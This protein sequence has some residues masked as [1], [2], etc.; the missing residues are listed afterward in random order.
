M[1]EAAIPRHQ[2]AMISSESPTVS[3]AV[4]PGT[5]LFCCAAEGTPL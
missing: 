1:P 4:L 5:P 2:D 3:G